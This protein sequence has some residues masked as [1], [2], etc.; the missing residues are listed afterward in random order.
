[1]EFVRSLRRKSTISGKLHE[2]FTGGSWDAGFRCERDDFVYCL[3]RKLN[4][5]AITAEKADEQCRV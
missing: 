1:M 3:R 4:W 2:S 5:A